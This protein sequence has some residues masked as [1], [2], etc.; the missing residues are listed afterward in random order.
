MDS[1]DK[2]GLLN[3]G[4]DFP[5]AALRAA[6]STVKRTMSALGERAD[7]RTGGFLCVRCDD[8]EQPFLIAQIGYV[9]REKADRYFRLCQEKAV[10]LAQHPD[11][12]LSWQSRDPSVEQYGGAVRFINRIDS[13]CSFIFSFSGLPEDGDEASMALIGPEVD[14]ASTESLLALAAISKN[15]LLRMEQNS[16]S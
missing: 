14:F 5:E 7:G 9:A 11:H 3:E 1:L 15:E 6:Y 4:V 8:R 12:R 13:A 2:K 16:S 10:R